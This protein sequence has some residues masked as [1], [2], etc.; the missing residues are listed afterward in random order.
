[1]KLSGEPALRAK[2]PDLHQFSTSALYVDTVLAVKKKVRFFPVRRAKPILA[3][4]VA[5]RADLTGLCWRKHGL[6]RLSMFENAKNNMREF[7][8]GRS[9]GA[10]FGVASAHKA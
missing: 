9:Q 3:L 8:H 4:D 10:H 1:M 5:W 2:P 6:I 7:A